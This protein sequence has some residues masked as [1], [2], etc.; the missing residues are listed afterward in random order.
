MGDIV[1][2]PEVQVK[3]NVPAPKKIG[4]FP[5]ETVEVIR[6]PEFDEGKFI[7]PKETLW[8]KLRKDQWLL[9][10]A[11]NWGMYWFI[12][13]DDSPFVTE[14][15]EEAFLEFNRK[16]V[17][18]F[19][20]RLKPDLI[21]KFERKT[22]TKAKRQGDLWAVKLPFFK[23]DFRTCTDIMDLLYGAREVAWLETRR[24]VFETRHSICGRVFD[25]PVEAIDVD[26]QVLVCEG[27]LNAPDHPPLVL[28]GAHLV[29]QSNGLTNSGGD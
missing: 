17:A 5:V 16:G 11:K 3:G 19:Y 6:S 23:E 10:V 25:T 7:V 24:T 8:F 15:T 18:A 22:K 9:H 28:K 20:S 4:K 26:Y 21:K 14:I 2:G 13:I 12:G 29:M 27:T 1:D